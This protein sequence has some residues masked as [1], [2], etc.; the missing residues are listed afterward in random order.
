[1]ADELPVPPHFDPARVGE[2]WRVAY[3]E[4]AREAETWAGVHRIGPSVDDG[5]R[6]CLVLVDCQNTFCTPGFELVVGAGT[7]DDS[8]RIAEF[9]YRNLGRITR[10]APTLDT[11]QA[12]QIFHSLFLVDSEGRHPEPYTLVTVSDV[13]GG[14]W[15]IDSAVARELG[16]SGDYLLHYVRAL[17]ESGKYDLTVWPYHAMLGG[18]GHALVSAVEEAVFFHAV[19]RRARVQLEVKGTDLLTEHYSALR[20]EVAE[21]RE[22]SELATTLTSYDAIVVA[23]QAKSHCVAWTVADLL[24]DFG[25]LARKVYLLEDCTSPVIVSGVVDY[26]KEADAAFR[27]FERAGVHLVR[28]TEPMSSWPA[29]TSSATPE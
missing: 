11:H 20:P 8:R 17:A 27:R 18:I 13:E 25:E 24:E 26:S 3:E 7:V 1:M 21:K 14:R 6:V 22:P 23:G 15:K 16:A 28:S 9:I 12:A 10:V 19:A 5:V 2:V 4:R 29:K